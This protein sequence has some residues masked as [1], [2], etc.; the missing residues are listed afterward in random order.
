M[1]TIFKLVI[2]V[3]VCVTFSCSQDVALESEENLVENARSVNAKNALNSV[4]KE[5][6][7][8]A[9]L[10]GANGIDIGQSGDIYVSGGGKNAI[11]RVSQN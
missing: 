6:V 9:A 10:H 8:G 7:H 3:I 1:K 2:L 11:Y 4:L 5:I